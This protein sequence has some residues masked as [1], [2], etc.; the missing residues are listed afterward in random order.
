MNSA[1]AEITVRWFVSHKSRRLKLKFSFGEYFSALQGCDGDFECRLESNCGSFHFRYGLPDLE[2][3]GFLL[4]NEQ[5]LKT[6][7]KSIKNCYKYI[8]CAPVLT[9]CVISEAWVSI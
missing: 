2:T 8:F 1:G 6:L 9:R 5:L 3:Y 7:F 4:L